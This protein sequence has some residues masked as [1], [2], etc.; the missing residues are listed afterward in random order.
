MMIILLTELLILTTETLYH[1][2]HHSDRRRKP[3]HFCGAGRYHHQR[4]EPAPTV[5]EGELQCDYP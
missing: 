2:G 1:T 5:G 3:K 4:K